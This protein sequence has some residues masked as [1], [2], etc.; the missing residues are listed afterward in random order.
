MQSN[1]IIELLETPE[2]QLFLNKYIN[3]RPENLAL[4]HSGKV[5]F[6]LTQTYPNLTFVSRKH[7]DKIAIDWV[8][9]PLC[10]CIRQKLRPKLALGDS[11]IQI[12]IV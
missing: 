2:A 5:T 7:N 12:V 10:H 3:E 8:D 4:T 6:Q 9:K 1:E 11:E